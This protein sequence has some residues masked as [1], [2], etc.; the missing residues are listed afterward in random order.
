MQTQHLEL[1]GLKVYT[2]PGQVLCSAGSQTQDFIFV[3]KAL[4]HK[5]YTDRLIWTLT[6]TQKSILSWFWRPW[7]K[8]KM[9]FSV[10][11]SPNMYYKQEYDGMRKN[12]NIKQNHNLQRLIT[13]QRKQAHSSLWKKVLA[14]DFLRGNYTLVLRTETMTRGV[15]MTWA[16]KKNVCIVPLLK[17]HL[18]DGFWIPL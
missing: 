12:N 1:L 16:S 6:L 15:P 8:Y 5:S 7:G 3:R 18:C 9:I 11:P 14:S 10:Y 4:Y 2:S 17:N 13:L